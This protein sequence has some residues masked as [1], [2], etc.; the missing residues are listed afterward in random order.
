MTSIHQDFSSAYS[1]AFKLLLSY[2]NYIAKVL[3]RLVLKIG[4]Q[5]PT[6]AVG[7]S[8]NKPTLFINESF[9]HE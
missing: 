1:K 3:A 8:D 2:D 4:D 5:V 9:F 6:L 7:I